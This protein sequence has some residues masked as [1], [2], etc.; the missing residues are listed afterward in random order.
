MLF[1]ILRFKI[2]R[3]KKKFLRLG[4]YNLPESF[5]HESKLSIQ[6]LGVQFDYDELSKEKSQFW[7]NPQ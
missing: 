1:K 7:S 4:V 3:R 2:E 5:P 6:I